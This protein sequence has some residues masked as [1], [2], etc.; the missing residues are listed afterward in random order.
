MRPARIRPRP[1]FFPELRK[2]QLVRDS[3]IEVE[4]LRRLRAAYGRR[5]PASA[6][7]AACRIKSLTDQLAIIAMGSGL[8]EVARIAAED[9]AAPLNEPCVGY[10][11]KYEVVYHL[12]TADLS[13]WACPFHYFQFGAGGARAVLRP[14]R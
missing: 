9:A 10:R 6:A 5:A 1:P 4:R 14:W 7:W 2:A 12:D 3:V 8:R 13:G 11:C